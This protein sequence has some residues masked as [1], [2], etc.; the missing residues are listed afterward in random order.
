MTLSSPFFPRY[1][2]LLLPFIQPASSGYYPSDANKLAV[3]RI[4]ITCYTLPYGGLGFA[5]H[6]LTYYTLF[7]LFSGRQPL[8]P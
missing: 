3:L 7:M 5:S 1:A 8:R 2:S 4:E 6:I